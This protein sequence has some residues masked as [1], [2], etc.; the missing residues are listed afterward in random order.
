M[1]V[2]GWDLGSGAAAASDLIAVIC[3][4]IKKRNDRTIDHPSSSVKSKDLI[5]SIPPFETLLFTRFQPFERQLQRQN[6]FPRLRF[7]LQ[8]QN[9]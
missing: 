5:E 3:I 7:R 6:R 9:G 2:A 8:E 4:A 1:D